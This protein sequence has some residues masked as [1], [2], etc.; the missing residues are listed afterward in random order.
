MSSIRFHS[1]RGDDGE[2][3][4]KR[5]CTHWK[6]FIACCDGAFFDG[7]VACIVLLVSLVCI[8]DGRF[9]G[10]SEEYRLELAELCTVVA[11]PFWMVYGIKDFENEVSKKG[12][13]VVL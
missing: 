5:G 13:R 4:C 12:L 2:R 9:F 8:R 11:R 10:F 7:D 3:C 6:G 1:S